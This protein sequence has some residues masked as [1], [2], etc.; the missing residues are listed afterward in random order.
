MSILKSFR[1]FAQGA[2]ARIATIVL[3]ATVVVAATLGLYAEYRR[4]VD[5]ASRRTVALAAATAAHVQQVISSI[6]FSM[7]SLDETPN[8]GQIELA[9]N[10]DTL[11]VRLSQIQASTGALYGIGLVDSNGYL[12]MRAGELYPVPVDLN[13]RPFVMAH[14]IDPKLGLLLSAPIAR[15]PDG[16]IAIPV[17]RGIRDKQGGFA[18]V[19]A[20][21]ID[22]DYFQRFFRALGASVVA[23]T[24]DD[25]TVLARYPEV[26]L[27]AASR[28][29][30]P[31]GHSAIASNFIGPSPIDGVARFTAFRRLANAPISVEVAIDEEEVL[32][33]W[34][35]KRDIVGGAAAAILCLLFA[36]LR[37]T[38]RHSRDQAV[39]RAMEATALVQLEANRRKSEFLAHMSHEIRTPLN[40]IIGFSQM[41]EGEVL[42]PVGQPR[43]RSYASDI[44][45]SAEHLLSVVNNVLDISKIEAGK[46]SLDESKFNL[47][48]LIRD[49]LRLAS[50]RAAQERVTLV[51]DDETPPG[52]LLLADRRA[53][54]QL[55]LNLTVNAIKFTGDDRTVRISAGVSGDGAICILV[56]DRGVGMSPEDIARA[57]RPFETAA[58]RNVRERQD[59]GLGLPLAAMFAAL[60]GGSLRLDSKPALGTTAVV[61]L[62]SS[63]AS[64]S[65]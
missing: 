62:P 54:A 13:D 9:S 16:K 63:R 60:H 28:V 25:G 15:R 5:T 47:G 44:L 36:V 7:R 42:G 24:L 45:H 1:L 30:P 10:N 40:A 32:A 22:P 49:T 19:L 55:L 14:R 56:V 65:D 26:D 8:D 29:A 34:R 61:M 39:R 23:I 33:E 57:L 53:M 58:S 41:I 27:L 11:R 35:R 38:D 3:V 6:D 17:S 43:Y 4:I 50:N 59:T 48:D 21:T 12:A 2:T 31:P 18:G 20:A 37:L 46:W 51:F 64:Y 52:M